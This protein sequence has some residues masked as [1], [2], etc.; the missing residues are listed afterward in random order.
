M[1]I[2]YDVAQI[3]MNGH[4]ISSQINS[5]PTVMQ[6]HCGRCGESTIIECQSCK[7][8]IHGVLIRNKVSQ[9][10]GNTH[11]E[12]LGNYRKP[13]YCHKCGKPFP[14]TVKRSE[15]AKELAD[16]FESLTPEE[17]EQ[18][19]GCLPDLLND[20]P[21][22]PVAEAVFKRLMRKAGKEAYKLMLKVLG[23]IASEAVKSV[24]GV[25]Q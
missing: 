10:T 25:E 3:C 2:A 14:W 15:A 22:T 13:S 9:Y 7:A 18:L 21:R 20:T 8:P 12:I 1:G 16:E 4:V 5:Y 6:G 11:Q 24:F 23:D 19:K 17:K